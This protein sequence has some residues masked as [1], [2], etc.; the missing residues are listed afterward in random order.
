MAAMNVDMK[1]KLETDRSALPDP[2]EIYAR[3]IDGKTNTIV[4]KKES[5]VEAL[6]DDFSL[7]D[8][9]HDWLGSLAIKNHHVYPYKY[10]PKYYLPTTK[11]A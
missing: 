10:N 3:T 6:D 7:M 8:R 11:H 1:K 2:I 9:V 5:L 4:I